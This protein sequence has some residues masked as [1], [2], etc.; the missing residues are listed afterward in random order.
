MRDVGKGPWRKGPPPSVGWWPA[1]MD[2]FKSRKALR[3]WNGICW[4][5]AVW[6]GV[7]YFPRELNDIANSTTT[8]EIVWRDR[9]DWWPKRS[10][11]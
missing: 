4:S 11:T 5:K 10:R 3:W 9:A 2:D 1:D 7:P 8:W 6:V